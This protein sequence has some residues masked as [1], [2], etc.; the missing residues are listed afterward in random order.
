MIT[1]VKGGENVNPAMVREFAGTIKAEKAEMGLFICL[2]KP[3]REMERAA[4]SDIADTVHGDI[5]KLQIVAIEDFFQGK[6][7]KLPPLEHLPSASFSTAR[8]RPSIG[9]RIADPNQPE[10]PLSYIGGKATQAPAIHFNRSMV[11]AT[12]SLDELSQVGRQPLAGHKRSRTKE[13]PLDAPLL[14]SPAPS[15]RR[16]A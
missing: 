10:L 5:P 6:L 9:K 11:H 13:L 12:T 14:V 7:P 15:K 1:S 16:R 2:R 8:R 4:G 3:T